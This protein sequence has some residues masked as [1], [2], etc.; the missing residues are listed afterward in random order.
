MSWSPAEIE[1]ASAEAAKSI[2]Y[3]SLKSEQQRVVSAFVSGRDVFVLAAFHLRSSPTLVKH[4]EKHRSIE[5]YGLPSRS[6]THSQ[7]SDSIQATYSR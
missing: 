1:H 5:L 3:T 6:C 4:C 2:G 7:T